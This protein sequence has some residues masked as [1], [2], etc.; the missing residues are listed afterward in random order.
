M[1][2]RRDESTWL[3]S[4]SV[5]LDDLLEQLGLQ[6]LRTTEPRD[7]TTVGGLVMSLLDRIPQNGDSAEWNGL[8]LEVVR[9]DGPRVDRILVRCDD[10]PRSDRRNTL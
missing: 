7:Y 2:V 3:V 5:N 9:M 4:G 1:V 10:L 8:H 6:E